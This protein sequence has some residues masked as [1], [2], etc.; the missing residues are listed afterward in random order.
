MYVL[1]DLSDR[2]DPAK[3]PDQKRK[4]V[5]II[6]NVFAI[7]KDRV[8]KRLYIQS[9]DR[10]QI[11]IAPQPVP[12]T[13][14]AVVYETLD[15]LKI[16]MGRLTWIQRSA[17]KFPALEK[18]FESNLDKLYDMAVKNPNFVGADIWG[19]F[20]DEAEN[21]MVASKDD[22]VRN[23]LI[24]L[25]DG[26]IQFGPAVM[27]NRP[28]NGNRTSYMNVRWFLRNPSEFAAFDSKNHGLIPF[29]ET[30]GNL[31]VLVLEVRPK[32]I[33]NPMEYDIIKKYW[34][35]WFDEMGITRRSLVKTQDSPDKVKQIIEDFIF[36]GKIS[37]YNPLPISPPLNIK[38]RS[39][40]PAETKI[41][42]KTASEEQNEPTV[43][44]D[45]S[46]T[47]LEKQ[48]PLTD[49]GEPL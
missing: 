35:K 12:T 40:K 4:D 27:P 22:S 24:I 46:E 18:A 10:I 29:N 1:L 23:I 20:K 26:Y 41:G 25:T 31:E 19:F 49:G 28:R 8:K 15:S 42:G 2:I 7:F 30:F 34:Y 36:S 13:Y 5:A 16:D 43:Q 44:K 38:L 47:S 33:S 37:D 21:H 48:T 11:A 14:S 17:K 9:K 32:Y 45:R 6:R 39:P 3:F